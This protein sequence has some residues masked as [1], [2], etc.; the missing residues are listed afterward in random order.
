[1]RNY[2][3]LKGGCLCG[4]IRYEFRGR[5]VRSFVCHC[6]DCRRSGGSLFHYGIMLPKAQFTVTGEPACYATKSDARR[7]IKRYFCATC[8]SGI[9]N[10]LEFAPQGIV[11]KG[12]TLDA[13]PAEL[14]PTAEVYVSSRSACC[15]FDQITQHYPQSSGGA[16]F[17]FDKD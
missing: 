14:M 17:Q 6:T 9:W 2:M 16:I 7:L 5:P 10:E 12:G 11:L 1:M 3:D 8:G 4:A 15:S 13:H